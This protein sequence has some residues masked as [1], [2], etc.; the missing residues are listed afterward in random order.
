M[1]SIKPIRLS[2][3]AHPRPG[4][5]ALVV[6]LLFAA[7]ASADDPLVQ[8][9]SPIALEP[10]QSTSSVQTDANGQP[11]VVAKTDPPK[12]AKPPQPYKGTG[13]RDTDFSYLEDPGNTAP[14]QP[15]D[16]L[17]R[18]HVGDCSLLDF[19]GEYRV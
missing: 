18:I 4:L 16:E 12:P 13:L 7:T 19:G 9:L 6:S 1:N 8:L 10:A 5:C 15:F 14:Y 3:C 11:L 2:I 17:K